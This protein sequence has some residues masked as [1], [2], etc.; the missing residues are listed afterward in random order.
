MNVS[1]RLEQLEAQTEAGLWRRY[2]A[3]HGAD[4]VQWDFSVLSD[5]VAELT[6]IDPVGM[7]KIQADIDAMSDEELE[8][9]VYERG[10][11][12]DNEIT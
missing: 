6:R 4:F 7:A 12:R 9:I 11:V 10:L 5:F 3:Q 8:R 2:T 1:K